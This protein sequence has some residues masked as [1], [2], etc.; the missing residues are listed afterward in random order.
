MPL[1]SSWFTTLYFCSF[2]VSLTRLLAET[3]ARSPAG[4]KHKAGDRLTV[5]IRQGSSLDLGQ[6]ALRGLSI[7]H[8]VGPGA[9]LYTDLY[10]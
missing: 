6:G 5:V 8:H 1:D 9:H 2:L 3:R 10:R 7:T 4:R